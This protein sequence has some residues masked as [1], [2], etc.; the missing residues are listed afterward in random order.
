VD[1][2]RNLSPKLFWMRDRPGINICIGWLLHD[3]L[4]LS[5]GPDYAARTLSLYSAP[6]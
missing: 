3:F 6:V 4:L 5:F 1:I 2:L